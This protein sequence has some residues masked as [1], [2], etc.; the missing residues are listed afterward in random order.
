MIW[1]HMLSYIPVNLAN[2]VISLG[3]VVVL[4][5]LFDGA[6]FGRY[7]LAVATLHFTHNTIFSWVEAGM[8]RYYARAEHT[9]TMAPHIKTCYAIGALVA[10]GGFV[11][12]MAVLF[13]LPLEPMMKTI[14]GFALGS[15]CLTLIY[16]LG[17][18]AHRAAHRIDRYSIVHGSQSLVGFGVGIFLIVATPLREAAPFIGIIIAQ[19][20]AL[21]FDLPFMA[22][23][24]KGGHIDKQRIKL[25]F[26]YGM[27]ISLALMLSYMLSQGDLFLIKY[28]MGDQAVGEYNAGYNLASRS[29]DVLFFWVGMAVT[30]IAVT[31]IEQE[32]LEKTKEILKNYGATILLMT[33]PAATGIA[34]VSQEAGFILGE[35]VRAEAIKVMPLIAFA[36]VMNGLVT[37]YVQ[38]AFMLSGHTHVMAM[39]MVAPVLLNIGMNIYLIPVYGLAGAVWSTV[40]AYALGL[41]ISLV[42][43]RRYF[44]LPLP[45]KAFTQ[46][47]FAC[48]VMAGI[49]NAVPDLSHFPDFIA[50]I[51]KGCI[52]SSVYALVVFALNAA[53]CR[54]LVKGVVEKFKSSSPDM[55][56]EGRS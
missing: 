52:G 15:T 48:L 46:C 56:V 49:V 14:I 39:I 51:I 30:P 5:R 40:A 6:E 50:L 16:N 24:M 44:P 37:Y 13:M 17:I 12:I 8:A 29:L 36:G 41:L 31:A 45:I 27:P 18:E 19:L 28:F 23:F 55:A 1:R 26:A 34:L 22:K 2:I 4:T 10:L 42:V 3:T 38:R 20:I 9:G 7:A 21:A 47:V 54:T 35:A 43:V 33:L 11:S 53:D 32:T 25:Y